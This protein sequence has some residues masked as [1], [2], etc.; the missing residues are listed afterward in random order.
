MEDLS[1]N[2]REALLTKRQASLNK[3]DVR[4]LVERILDDLLVLLDGDGT[5][6]VDDVSARLAVVVDGVDSRQ[7]QLLL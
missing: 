4:A 7:D 6:R 5:C 1:S 2:I 3:L